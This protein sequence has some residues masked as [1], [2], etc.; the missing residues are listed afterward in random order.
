MRKTLIVLMISFCVMLFAQSQSKKQKRKIY[1]TQTGAIIE[2]PKP[3]FDRGT[4]KSKPTLKSVQSKAQLERM[5]LQFQ[6]DLETL[7]SR[8]DELYETA[9]N[10]PIDTVFIYTTTAL[11]DTVTVYDTSFIYTNATTTVYDT[12][13]MID[14]VYIN[15]YDTTTIIQTNM[16]TVVVLDTS[17]VFN[18]D[19]TYVR[20]TV[21]AFARDT[22][23][24]YDTSWVFAYDTTVIRDSLWLFAFDTTFFYDTLRIFN[25]D[26]VTIHTHTSGF[27]PDM[28]VGE[29]SKFPKWNTLDDAIR[30]RDNGDPTAQEWINKAIYEAGGNWT[31]ASDEYKKL[32]KV[33]SSD[34]VKQILYQPDNSRIG[35]EMK[36]RSVVFDTLKIVT[37]DTTVVKDTVRDLYKQTY[38][39]FD[40]TKIANRKDIIARVTPPGHELIL[41]YH[42]NGNVRERGLMKDSK[43]NGLWTFY[44]KNGKEIRKTT[45]KNGQITTDKDLNAMIQNPMEETTVRKEKKQEKSKAKKSRKLLIFPKRK[46]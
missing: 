10:R 42:T 23:Y 26:T 5:E 13:V 8:I 30:A 16:D 1:R 27:A 19:T 9:E 2:A 14:S 38:V 24:V 35:P 22:T 6:D 28:S 40:T 29:R 4:K 39:K 17:F 45:Y 25:N 43:R 12:V 18:Y 3:L 37:F 31:L 7:K 32:Q 11:Y 21:W 20:D 15:Q 33:Y 34:L 44:D 41:R 36:Y 46:K